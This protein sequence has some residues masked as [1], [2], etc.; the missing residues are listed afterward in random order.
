MSLLCIKLIGGTKNQ[1]SGLFTD[2][3]TTPFVKSK[4]WSKTMIVFLPASHKFKKQFRIASLV[5]VQ[6]L[7][8][9]KGK[10]TR[11]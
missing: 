9:Q 4:K 2:R 11:L 10:Q 5:V 3:V 8:V 1:L 6:E 7:V